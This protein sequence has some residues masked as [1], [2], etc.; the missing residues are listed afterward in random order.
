MGNK[1]FIQRLTREFPFWIEKGWVSRPNA[2]EI[3]TNL[4]ERDTRSPHRLV[5]F[6]SLLGVILFGTGVITFFSAHWNGM[7]KIVKLAILFGGMWSA[8]GFALYFSENRPS[9]PLYH[10]ML[11][12]GVVLFGSNIFLIS[13]IYHIDSHYPNG[14]LLWSVGALLASFLMKS[15]VSMFPAI[16]L[17]VLWSGFEIFNFNQAFFW[18]FLILW[19]LS[20]FPIFKHEWKPAFHAALIGLMIWSFMVFQQSAGREAAPVFMM[21]TYFLAY[22][23]LFLLGRIMKSYVKTS[24]LSQIFQRYNLSAM[25]FCIYILTFP[26]INRKGG[27]LIGINVAQMSGWT[28]SILV[29]AVLCAGLFLWLRERTGTFIKTPLMMPG[30]GLIAV[31]FCVMLA[32]GLIPGV[33]GGVIPVLFNLIFFG[34]LV[35]FVYA[36]VQV[37]D[38][39]LVNLSF[40]FFALTLLSRY[41]DTFWSLLNRSYFFMLGGLLLIGGGLF[42]ERE[43]RKLTR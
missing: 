17:S 7:G 24:P 35:W 16:L 10:T 42:L 22:L 30:Y 14:I 20:L 9:S 13:Q 19:V 41:F 43:R 40:A 23:G 28:L 5:L 29:M 38:P 12:L 18:P 1:K 2:E 25:L 15:Q 4:S 32:N 26:E 37:H 11:L 36:G 3:I 33:R 27:W 39:F 6:L 21:Q 34:G 31:L 8:Y